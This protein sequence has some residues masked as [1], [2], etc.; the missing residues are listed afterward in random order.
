[1]SSFAKKDKLKKQ[2]DDENALQPE[3]VSLL[4]AEEHYLNCQAAREKHVRGLESLAKRNSAT[5]EDAE[6]RVY[7]GTRRVFS[8]MSVED[9]TPSTFLFYST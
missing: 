2:F 1:M 9:S 6:T 4:P 8:T 5:D 3:S 7:I